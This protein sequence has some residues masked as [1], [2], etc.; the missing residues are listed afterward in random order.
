MTSSHVSKGTRRNPEEKSVK[1]IEQKV[2]IIIIKLFKLQ[3][4]SHM[5]KLFHQFEKDSFLT[6]VPLEHIERLVTSS[7]T[8][9]S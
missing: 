8:V 4:F 3:I 9:A 5:Y 6:E 1:D 7:K 2:Y